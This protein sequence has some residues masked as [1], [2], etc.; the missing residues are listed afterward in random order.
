[1][2]PCPR[3]RAREFYLLA[4]VRVSSSFLSKVPRKDILGDLSLS[5]ILFLLKNKA[6]CKW[7][8]AALTVLCRGSSVFCFFP[9]CFAA[10]LLF[11][12]R[13]SSGSLILPSPVLVWKLG[14][15][16]QRGS[17]PTTWNLWICAHVSRV[18]GGDFSV[19]AAVYLSLVL[20]GGCW[21]AHSPLVSYWRVQTRLL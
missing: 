12:W 1:M 6:T 20:G 13:L 5:K 15:K 16:P 4:L 14:S 10:D 3:Q 21:I 17:I 18:I 2:R 8:H 9:D 7:T 11:I 19:S